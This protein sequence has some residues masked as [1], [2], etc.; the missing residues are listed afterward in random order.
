MD[1]MLKQ[2]LYVAVAIFLLLLNGFFVAAEF[3]L[4]KVRGSQVAE[5]E[6]QGRPFASTARWL[7][8]RLEGALSACQLGITMASLALGHV[9]EPAFAALLEPLF[10]TLGLGLAPA[11]LHTISFVIAFTTISSLHLVAGEQFPKI[12]AIRRPEQVLLWTALPMK[13][14]YLA[15]YPL[16]VALNSST[17]VLLGLIG[18]HGAGEHDTPHSEEEIRAMLREAHIHG[19][20]TGSEH[21]LLN[22]VFEF[23]DMV[24]RR[25]MVPRSEVEFLDVG[26]PVSENLA[27]IARTKHTRYPV[28]HGSL[29]ELLG[30]LHVKD[31]LGVTVEDG[32]DWTGPARPPRKVPESLPISK[33]LRPFQA[34]PQLMAFVVG[35]SNT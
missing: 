18:I 10:E 14:F 4:V 24:C 21:R 32:F 3:A 27:R 22:A 29:D 26:D 33:V 7:Y 34:T 23:D 9:G 25:V 12:F 1:P 30:V 6:R 28:C 16:M 20:L 8:E 11:A 17:D 31:L 13:W 2:A 19:N 35:G 5:M 15:S